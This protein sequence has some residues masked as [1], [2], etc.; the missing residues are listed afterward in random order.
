MHP[1]EPSSPDDAIA[2]Y[3]LLEEELRNALPGR[4]TLAR[5]LALIGALHLRGLPNIVTLMGPSGTGKTTAVRMLASALD[6]PLVEVSVPQMAETNFQGTDLTDHI[7]A[8]IA[9]VE[10][11]RDSGRSDVEAL[12]DATGR[13]VVFLDDF[14]H[15]RLSTRSASA[16][17]R[18]HH[19]GQQLSLLTLLDRGTI[20][21]E[22][23]FSISEWSARRALIVVAGTFEGLTAV[24]PS[25][26]DLVAWGLLSELAERLA[27]GSI[28]RLMPFTGL[29]LSRVLNAQLVTVR[30]SFEALGYH[31]V[32]PDETLAYV[33]R[34]VE[35]G[36]LEAGP[37]AGAGWI[38]DA[39]WRRLLNLVHTDAPRHSRVVIAPDDIR[40]PARPRWEWRE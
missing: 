15:L 20:V 33:A 26:G 5:R 30:E 10:A 1:L 2:L 24:A 25:A 21:V 32:V 11:F 31:L 4:G 36:M 23:S 6:V 38:A 17:S 39:A 22:R 8:M 14:S 7:S 13:A 12:K 35:S 40:V 29:G 3:R 16:A 37:R 9:R 18:D 34:C 27:N 28:I 19:V